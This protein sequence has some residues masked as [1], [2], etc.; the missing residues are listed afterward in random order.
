[1]NARKEIRR[2]SQFLAAAAGLGL[3]F[4]AFNFVALF[5]PITPRREGSSVGA[6]DDGRISWFT[7]D[8]ELA[9]AVAAAAVGKRR[10]HVAM[11]AMADPYSR[12]Q[13]RIMYYWYGSKNDAYLSLHVVVSIVSAN[14]LFQKNTHLFNY[15]AYG[16]R[17]DSIYMNVVLL[18][19]LGSILRINL[20]IYYYGTEY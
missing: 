3:F 4:A 2:A 10:F 1:M 13:S 12:W 20:L 14:Q 9:A 17:P 6:D 15:D 16:F 5:V 8:R 11:T 18:N 7:G 19:L